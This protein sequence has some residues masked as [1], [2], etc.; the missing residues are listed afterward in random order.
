MSLPGHPGSD[1]VSRSLTSFPSSSLHSWIESSLPLA[2]MCTISRQILVCARTNQGPEKGDLISLDT[3]ACP[4]A[5]RYPDRDVTKLLTFSVIL[6]NDSTA[7]PHH[8]PARISGQ[9]RDGERVKRTEWRGLVF[10]AH[11]WLYHSTLGSRV[12][13]K[14]KKLTARTF[15]ELSSLSTSRARVFSNHRLSLVLILHKKRI[16]W[17]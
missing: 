8:V 3:P 11:T 12:I 4:T 14:K 2:L 7:A 13:K 5:A 10:K 15:S 1:L 16:P 17:Y 9:G 6:G